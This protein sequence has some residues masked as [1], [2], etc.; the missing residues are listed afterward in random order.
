M[1]VITLGTGAP[2]CPDR[3]G[4]GLLL[5]AEG[6]EPL[7]IDSC[8]GLE[9]ARQLARVKEPLESLKHVILSHRHGDHIGGSMA[10]ALARVP[11]HYYGLSDTLEAVKALIQLS[12]GEYDLHPETHYQAIEAGQSYTIAGYQV[13]FYAVQHRVP[14]VAMRISAGDKVF[15]YSADSLP[16][17]ALL[18]CAREADLFICDALCASTDYDAQRI[19]F[20]MHPTA[21]EAAQMAAKANVKS[22]VLLHLARFAQKDAMLAEAKTAFSGAI[23][24]AE[25]GEVFSI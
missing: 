7:L 3:A 13:S 18:D 22:L 17:A 4:L 21:L 11:C 10:L 24:I 9:L 19:S 23:H 20:L 25:D 15:A 6:L 14:T 1:Q 12:Y 2:L 5:R 16:C 8:G